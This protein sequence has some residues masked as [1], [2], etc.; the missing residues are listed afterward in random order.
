MCLVWLEEWSSPFAR[1]KFMRGKMVYRRR[2]N[3]GFFARPL[4]IVNDTIAVG[5]GAADVEDVGAAPLPPDGIK[6]GC[7]EVPLKESPS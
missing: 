5:T 4:S 6:L 2:A 3:G 1:N 7:Y